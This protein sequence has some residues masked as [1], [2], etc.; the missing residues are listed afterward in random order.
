MSNGKLINAGINVSKVPKSAIREDNNGNKWLNVD[1]WI[2]PDADD[3][4]N[5]ASINIQQTKEQRDAKEKKVYIGNGKKMFG[6]DDAPT[7]SMMTGKQI[8]AA[9]DDGDIPF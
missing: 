4:G 5:H 8:K 9:Q 2:N 3:Y 1:I 7:A 6:W